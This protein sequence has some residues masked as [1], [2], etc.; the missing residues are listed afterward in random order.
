MIP[1]QETSQGI[2]LC[3]D[4]EFDPSQ[5]LD[6]G[7]CFRWEFTLEG[8]WSGTALGSR[9]VL[10]PAGE[11]WLLEGVCRSEFETKWIPYFDLDTDYAA[12]RKD[13]SNYHPVLRRAAG[14]AAGIRILRQDPWE[15][16]CSFILSQNNNIPRIKG[17]V[18]RLC[19]EF[20][21]CG[22]IVFPTPERLAGLNV[23]DL[24][25][26]RSGFRAKYLLSAAR[27]VS[28]GTVDLHSLYHIPLPEARDSLM[29]INGVGKKVAECV[30]LYGFHRL[31]AFPV[32]VWI[33]RAMELYF[34]GMAPEDFGPYAG[35]AQQYIFH[36]IRSLPKL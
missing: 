5:T 36:Y 11:G 21:E 14:F 26:L 1:Y 32:D 25:P 19:R 29:K 3:P 35:V 15:A 10:S 13:L 12:I 6:C 16:L 18:F 8:T 17:I 7:Q 34:P 4:P 28:S 22:G 2:L 33:K 30:L 27:L 24:A 9:L 23:E 31:D 20:G